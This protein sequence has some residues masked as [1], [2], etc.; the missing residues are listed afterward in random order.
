[1]LID[2]AVTALTKDETTRLSKSTLQKRLSIQTQLSAETLA[3]IILLLPQITDSVGFEGNAVKP[4][5]HTESR[6]L[7]SSARFEMED[8]SGFKLQLSAIASHNHGVSARDS[9]WIHE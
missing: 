8:G 7:P 4:R 5:N 6:K 3:W 1:M 9:L 2:A